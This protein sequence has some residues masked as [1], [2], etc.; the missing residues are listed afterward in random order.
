MFPGNADA[1]PSYP[2]ASFLNTC[3]VDTDPELCIRFL[4]LCCSY[5]V[6]ANENDIYSIK[7][8]NPSKTCVNDI[9]NLTGNCLELAARGI[10]NQVPCNSTFSSGCPDDFFSSRDLYRCMFDLLLYFLM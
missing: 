6:Y 10:L 5:T 8:N 3:Y 1:D 4:S 9:S 7:N 2:D